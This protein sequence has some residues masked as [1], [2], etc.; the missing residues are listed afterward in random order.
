[1]SAAPAVIFGERIQF[2]DVLRIHPGPG[3]LAFATC[4][5]LTL[6]AGALLDPHALW[7]EEARA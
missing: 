2:G 3:A 7:D 1:M 4:V 5:C 6:V